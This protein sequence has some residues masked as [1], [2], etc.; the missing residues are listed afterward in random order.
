MADQNLFHPIEFYR[1]EL[2]TDNINDLMDPIIIED[3][4]HPKTPY[5]YWIDEYNVKYQYEEEILEFDDSDNIKYLCS[6]VIL[7]KWFKKIYNR[8]IIKIATLLAKSKVKLS[9]HIILDFVEFNLI[10]GKYN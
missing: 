8:R 6:K 3:I 1:P 5:V 10:N 4:K 2:I 7:Y 9:Q